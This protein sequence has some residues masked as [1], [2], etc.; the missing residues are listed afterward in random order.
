M[1]KKKESVMHNLH[2]A[3]MTAFGRSEKAVAWNINSAL[4]ASVADARRAKR[5]EELLSQ[6]FED[7][8]TVQ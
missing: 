1:G 5:E 6:A 4:H 3:Y 7:A 2:V 8:V